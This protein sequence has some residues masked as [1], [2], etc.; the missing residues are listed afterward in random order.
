[1]HFDGFEI[2]VLDLGPILMDGGGV[3]GIIPKPLWQRII[4]GDGRNRVRLGLNSLLIRSAEHCVLV[5]TGMG[6]RRERSFY[7]LYGVEGDERLP[8]RLAERQIEPGAVTD[9][10]LTHLHFPSTGGGATLR[11]A[12]VV[13]TFVNAQYI[14]QRAEW[15]DATNTNERT[16]GSYFD[17]DFKPLMEAGQLRLLDGSAEIASGVE[18]IL[19]GG[20]TAGHQIVVVSAGGQ[21]IAFLGHFIPTAWHLAPHYIMAHDLYPAE[22]LSRK[23][24]FL[25]QAAVE[26]WILVF[27]NNPHQPAGFVKRTEIG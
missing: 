4:P 3:F 27:L 17:D 20:H 11:G 13:P 26:R 22:T 25:D 19:T 18:V 6:N 24:S 16:R 2:D 10:V 1:M 15:E 12:A 7:E 23:K 14:L 8:Q 9:V 5:E 21:K